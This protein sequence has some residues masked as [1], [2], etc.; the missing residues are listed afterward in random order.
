L[1]YIAPEKEP[2][3]FKYYTLLVM[4]Y[5]SLLIVSVLL[6]YKFIS[7]GGFLASTAT[8]L[9]SSTFFLSDVITE[10][11]GYQRGKQV[12]WSGIICLITIATIAYALKNLPTPTRYAEYGHAY[13]IIL[14][15]LFRASFA[16]A[17]AIAV[18]S[19][20]NVYFISKWKV[21]VK[22]KYFW[23]RSLGS[24]IIGESFYTIFVVSLVNIGIISFKE[25]LQ[26][27][28]VSYCY[29]LVFD[30][31]AVTPAS[32]LARFLKRSE[33]VDVY[34]FPKKF[35]SSKYSNKYLK[36]AND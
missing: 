10:V 21:L 35:T 13:E 26:I 17:V 18:G 16:N 11:Y 2:I 4:M 3:V 19:I 22:G 8:F 20:F 15:L 36:S 32:L 23:L 24:S 14:S 6:D 31:I 34:D 25:I 33:G 12:I 7:I 29:K 28:L 5:S 9:I 30:L 1:N 27:F